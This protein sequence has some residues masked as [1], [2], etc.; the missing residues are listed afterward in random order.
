MHSADYLRQLAVSLDLA[1]LKRGL[2]IEE[3]S[4][5]LG[6]T[7]GELEGIRDCRADPAFTLA[8]KIIA[9]ADYPS[10]TTGP[11]L[12]RMESKLD[13]LLS[14]PL[15][16][17]AVQP[18]RPFLSAESKDRLAAVGSQVGTGLS[19]NPVMEYVEND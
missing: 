10:L 2:S 4:V 19:R 15:S 3:F 6:C 7:V 12:S 1:L 8:M 16:E 5:E 11:Q 17:G 18:R 9:A 13:P 14:V